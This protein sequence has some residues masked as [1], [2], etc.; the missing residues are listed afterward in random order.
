[1][2]AQKI[3]KRLAIRNKKNKQNVNRTHRSGKI[4]QLGLTVTYIKKTMY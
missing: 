2:T 3:K 4:I 1:M